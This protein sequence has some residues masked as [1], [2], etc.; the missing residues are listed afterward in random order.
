MP[1]IIIANFKMSGTKSFI[2][3]WFD[4]FSKEGNISNEIIVALPSPFLIDFADNDISV[5]AQNV[6]SH[7]SGAFTNTPSEPFDADMHCLK[8]LII[9]LIV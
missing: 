3:Q 7:T 4:D 5:A 8:V 6:S 1:K 9:C 2:T